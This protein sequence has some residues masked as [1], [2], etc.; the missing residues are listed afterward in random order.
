MSLP[1]PREPKSVRGGPTVVEFAPEPPRQKR[2]TKLDPEIKPDKKKGKLLTSKEFVDKYR[3]EVTTAS[4]DPTILRKC[5]RGAE[6]I[7]MTL[8]APKKKEKVSF[9]ELQRRKQL[10]IDKEELEGPTD[11]F[12]PT[13]SPKLKKKIFS[14]KKG[15][16][17]KKEKK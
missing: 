12:K 11:R 6:E 8:G 9:H 16:D 7:L 10:I 5:G 14:K 1:Q 4:W 13:I 15:N 2:K 17:K 3:H